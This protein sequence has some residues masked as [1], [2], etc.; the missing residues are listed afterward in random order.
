MDAF[1]KLQ[2]LLCDDNQETIKGLS[3]FESLDDSQ[4]K[5]GFEYVYPSK[6]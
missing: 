5:V 4:L 3:L 2:T 1:E 6:S